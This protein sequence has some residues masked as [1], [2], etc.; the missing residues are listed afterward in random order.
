MHPHHSS[1]S[2]LDHLPS[3]GPVGPSHPRS[4]RSL[5]RAPDQSASTYMSF[6]KESTQSCPSTSRD[7]HCPVCLQ[8]ASFPVQTNCGHLF[9]APCLIAYWR[10][11]SWLDA[12]SC[13]LCRQ[14]VSVLCNLFNE[15]RS[16][17]SKEVLGEIT[18][19]NKRYSGT[20]RR[21]TDYLCDA[22]L[23]LQLLAR[24]LG[25]MGGLVWL[26][27]F[28]VALC[29]VGTVVSISSPP[30]APVSSSGNPL[31]AD[32][33]LCG[34]LGVLDDLVV[35]ILLLICVI[36]INQRMAPESRE[37]STHA[38]TPQGVIGSSL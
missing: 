11:G 19:Y 4:P 13:P 1:Q 6:P 8:T 22:P 32:S 18:D 26:F 7:W 36:N 20:P 34:L 5:V 35:V 9:C 12:I 10:H 31:E 29:C 28:R 38:T 17:Q 27:F 37:H 15:S 24:G 33:S 23:L 14:K 21:V 3:E 2:R 25:T 16:D 30:L